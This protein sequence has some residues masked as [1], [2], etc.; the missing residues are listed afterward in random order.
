M[1][2]PEPIPPE[3]DLRK[4]VKALKKHI[5]EAKA[6]LDRAKRMDITKFAPEDVVAAFA[7]T[8]KAIDKIYEDT[9]ELVK[10]AYAERLADEPEIRTG[11]LIFEAQRFMNRFGSL[12]QSDGS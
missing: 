1:V 3:P 4:L 12:P 10:I 5:A 2:A 9:I 8:A 6:A 7:E 11:M